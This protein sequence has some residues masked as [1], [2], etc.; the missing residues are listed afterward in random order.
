M[1][2]SIT[3]KLVPK[4]CTHGTNNHAYAAHQFQ[5]IPMTGSCIL[6]DRLTDT[7]KTQCP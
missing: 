5:L 6:W 3:K 4:I 7:S 1:P 2:L